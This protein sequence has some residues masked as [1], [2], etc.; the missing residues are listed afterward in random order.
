MQL[1]NSIIKRR[2]TYVSYP[3]RQ[4]RITSHEHAI[5]MCKKGR[6]K[7]ACVRSSTFFTG[8]CPVG[9]K[10]VGLTNANS[11]EINQIKLAG[12]ACYVLRLCCADR[13]F[14][15]SV[16]RFHDRN[17][18]HRRNPQ[19]CRRKIYRLVTIRAVNTHG[20]SHRSHSEHEQADRNFS[21]AAA[22]SARLL[23]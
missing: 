7:L 10:L 9:G 11:R 21:R 4:L 6:A 13:S 2:K 12:C 3:N 18:S 15:A 16:T 5:R 19:M 23:F 14:G 22:R 17:A 20:H 8:I 1:R